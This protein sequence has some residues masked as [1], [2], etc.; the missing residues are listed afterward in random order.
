VEDDAMEKLSEPQ[1]GDF[2]SL[3]S[4][5]LRFEHLAG[6]GSVRNLPFGSPFPL[7]WLFLTSLIA[8]KQK[9]MQQHAVSENSVSFIYE[10]Q[11]K[12]EK[13]KVNLRLQNPMH[14]RQN[15]FRNDAVEFSRLVTPDY[16]INS[17]RSRSFLTFSS[18]F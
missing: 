18:L 7:A 12:N 4:Y 1:C 16:T 14:D 17:S 8:A 11:Q 9:A 5:D 10:K 2:D 3:K 15:P 13:V 6:T